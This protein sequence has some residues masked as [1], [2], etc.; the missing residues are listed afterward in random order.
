M[1]TVARSPSALSP[2]YREQAGSTADRRRVLASSPV[3][4]SRVKLPV[5]L[6]F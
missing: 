3:D 5:F 6:R 2:D 4:T 1:T